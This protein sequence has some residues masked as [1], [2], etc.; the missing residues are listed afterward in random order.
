MHTRGNAKED[1]GRWRAE[2]VQSE[3]RRS[4]SSDVKTGGQGRA[5]VGSRDLVAIVRPGLSRRS[6]SHSDYDTQHQPP[7]PL[8]L[9]TPSSDMSDFQSLLSVFQDATS[10][11]KPGGGGGRGPPDPSRGAAAGKQNGAAASAP[12]APPPIDPT[13]TTDPSFSAPLLKQRIEKVMRVQQIRRSAAAGNSSA[14]DGHAGKEGE[15]ERREVH[16][17]ICATI[18]DEFPHEAL[19]RKWMEGTGG[20]F[21]VARSANNGVATNGKAHT[22]DAGEGNSSNNN[23]STPFAASAEL[24]VHAKN[25]ERVRSE[26]VRSKTIPVSHRPN[27]NDVRIVRAILSLLEAALRDERTTHVLLCTESCVPVATL[28]ET[29]RSVLLDEVCPWEEANGGGD[30]AGMGKGAGNGRGKGRRID[31]D[32]S[33]VDCYG[34]DSGRCT[35]FD[36]HNCWG[37]LK[38]SVPAEAIYKALPGWCF[39]SRKHAHSILDLPSQLEGSNLWPAFERVWAPEEVFVPT[40]LAIG[41]HMEEVVRRPLTHSQWDERAANHKDR[42]HPLAYDG[43]FDDGLVSRV[44]RDGC[45]FLRKMKRPLNVDVWEQIVVQ[46]RRGRDAGMPEESRG[47]EREDRYQNGGRGRNNRAYDSRYESRGSHHGN[48]QRGWDRERSGYS[49]HDQK[50]QRRRW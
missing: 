37:I 27:W 22:S 46:R 43:H 17:A 31:W 30:R 9:T 39:L 5:G 40:A 8:D 45:L 36:E 11:S 35:R 10:S 33:Y 44:R 16:I 14:Q 3:Q 15:K 29:A 24:Y 7:G 20:E 23:E 41:G 18:V 48:H 19:W 26:W 42:A 32:R 34:R 28:R 1:R 2:A 13:S 25:P 12:K 49:A 21:D 38:D 4:R 6:N 47:R 50:R